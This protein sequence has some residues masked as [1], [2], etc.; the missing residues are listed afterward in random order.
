MTSLGSQ[1]YSKSPKGW[2][3]SIS[4]LPRGFLILLANA[5]P[6]SSSKVMNAAVG[7]VIL[8]RSLLSSSSI[9]CSVFLTFSNF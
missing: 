8:A 9:D 5:T 7:V 3:G 1:A 4:K 6:S 2:P